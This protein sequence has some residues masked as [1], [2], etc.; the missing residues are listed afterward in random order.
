MG[1]D[2]WDDVECLLVDDPPDFIR[3]PPLL[4]CDGSF[5][6]QF[7]CSNGIPYPFSINTDGVQ[8]EPTLAIIVVCVVLFS[9][10]L[11]V[12]GVCAW[13][14][15]KHIRRLLS[16]LSGSPS[17]VRKHSP[18]SVSTSDGSEG[19]GAAA[20]SDNLD[21]KKISLLNA[22]SPPSGVNFLTDSAI[23]Y[24]PTSTL[25]SQQRQPHVDGHIY[26][27]I[28][29]NYPACLTTTAGYYHGPVQPHHH[30]HYTLSCKDGTT[31]AQQAF[32][33]RQSWLD[34]L[35]R[36][37]C[38]ETTFNLYDDGN[39]TAASAC[40]NCYYPSLPRDSYPRIDMPTE[41]GHITIN[42]VEQLTSS[43]TGK[44][45][46]RTRPYQ[47][48]PTNLSDA[49]TTAERLPQY[50]NQYLV[51][52]NN[53]RDPYQ[54]GER[55]HTMDAGGQRKHRPSRKHTNRHLQGQLANSSDI[56]MFRNELQN[57]LRNGIE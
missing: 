25:Q 15:K 22:V 54:R 7:T 41:F 29:N 46:Q 37:P 48:H 4:F 11:T 39:K 56:C 51:L 6:E 44:R 18:A 20:Y 9:V 28:A 36:P 2:S 10:A 40:P 1:C 43:R 30:A 26:E 45:R 16:C 33:Q 23:R 8:N 24:A 53:L 34:L 55:V 14:N 35:Q 21:Y 32:I 50:L 49:D 57:D 31:L 12:S 52:P 38:L 27:E 3:P 19:S 5:E 47:L 13:R 42:P 17:S